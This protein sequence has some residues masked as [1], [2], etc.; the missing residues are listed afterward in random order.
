MT[1]TELATL[2]R[3]LAA[4]REGNAYLCLAHL[5]GLEIRAEREFAAEDAHHDAA[6]ADT[7]PIN[8]HQIAAE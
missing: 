5:R 2:Q 4:L 6:E 8:A 7:Y 3:A 1:R